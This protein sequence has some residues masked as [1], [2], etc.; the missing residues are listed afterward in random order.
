MQ[1][2]LKGCYSDSIIFYMLFKALEEKDIWAKHN[3]RGK[4]KKPTTATEQHL[5]FCKNLNWCTILL[6]TSGSCSQDPDGLPPRRPQSIIK[7][8]KDEEQDLS[9]LVRNTVKCTN[10]NKKLHRERIS[11][12]FWMNKQRWLLPLDTGVRPQQNFRSITGKISLFCLFLVSTCSGDVKQWRLQVT[13]FHRDRD[14]ELFLLTLKTLLG[15][16]IFF[17]PLQ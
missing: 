1:Q 16:W 13:N 11:C 8:V 15:V 10:M 3:R 12:L 6:S 7:R 5:R 9:V 17:A 4:K 14:T 2:W